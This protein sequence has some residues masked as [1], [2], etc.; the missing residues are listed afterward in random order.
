MKLSETKL[1]ETKL[2]E[3]KWVKQNLDETYLKVFHRRHHVSDSSGRLNKWV[4]GTATVVARGGR[5]HASGG[6]RR[7]VVEKKSPRLWK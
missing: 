5:R 4:V 1:C 7:R 6:A 3:T 2:D